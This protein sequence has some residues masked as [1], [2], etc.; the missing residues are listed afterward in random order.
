MSNAVVYLE[1]REYGDLVVYV[2][3]GGV[4][5]EEHVARLNIYGALGES[6]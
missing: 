4:M 6:E 2:C 3:G 1:I 5:L